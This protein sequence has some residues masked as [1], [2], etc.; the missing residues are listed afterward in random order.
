MIFYF[1]FDFSTKLECVVYA[2]LDITAVLSQLGQF[3][4]FNEL[5]KNYSH[6]LNGTSPEQLFVKGIE[7]I[8][9][10][11]ETESGKEDTFDNLQEAITTF[12]ECINELM[13]IDVFKNEI[14]MFSKNGS[15]EEVFGKYCGRRQRA[16]ACIDDVKGHI[17]NCLNENEKTKVDNGRIIIGDLLE[18]LCFKEGDHIAC[19]YLLNI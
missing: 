9:E 13:D 14:E 6:I 15:L 16:L 12:S 18:F 19:K 8:K 2:Q 4:Q 5:S 7:G 3:S 1:F 11:C 10:K 17:K